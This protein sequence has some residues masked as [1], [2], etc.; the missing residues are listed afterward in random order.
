[1]SDPAQSGQVEAV[2]GL[3]SFP[4]R[5]TKASG[6]RAIPALVFVGEDETPKSF[7][8]LKEVV[9]LGS[10]ADSDL[11]LSG[12]ES[13]HAEIEVDSTRITIR[14]LG[15]GELSVNRV[16][17]DCAELQPGDVIRLNH[18]LCVL[19]LDLLEEQND[20]PPWQV[21]AEGLFQIEEPERPGAGGV[22][23]D[24]LEWLTLAQRLNNM[25]RKI[26]DLD[27]EDQMLQF[28]A[29]EIIE[30]LGATFAFAVILEEDGRNPALVAK[31]YRLGFDPTE[32]SE[33]TPEESKVEEAADAEIDDEVLDKVVSG[34]GVVEFSF[35]DDE[36]EAGPRVGLG[37]AVV[38]K[39]R[40]L[41]VVYFE[42]P[43][44]EGDLTAVD[45]ELLDLTARILALPMSH[46]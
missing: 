12:L 20:D 6:S 11:L 40:S 18:C 1:M 13:V 3:P 25:S 24:S 28:V 38:F 33:Q 23:R 26:G 31:S 9:C 42:R 43:S 16:P 32:A 37:A 39:D 15:E 30:M 45:S 41:G 35:D 7:P 8:I 29:S 27:D 17:T 4:L 46:L 36:D 22:M 21:I 10:S 2:P 44:A 14:K 34:K 19:S 5:P